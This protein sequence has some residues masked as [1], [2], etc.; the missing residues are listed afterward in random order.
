MT[1]TIQKK[2][3][4]NMKTLKQYAKEVQSATTKE[5][6]TKILYEAF[7]QDDKAFTRRRTLYNKVADICIKRAYEI[8][9]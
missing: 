7:F 3:K 9:A 6:L 4:N 8:L 2:E 1:T 5:E